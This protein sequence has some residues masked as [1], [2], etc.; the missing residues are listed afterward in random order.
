MSDGDFARL[1]ALAATGIGRFWSRNIT[2]GGA[3]YA[4][5]T[6]AV[7]R[8]DRSI[9][10]DLQYS[11]ARAFDRSHNSGFIDATIVYNFGYYFDLVSRM[12]PFVPEPLRRVLAQVN[13]DIE[14]LGTAAHEFGHSVL[15]ESEGKAT[16]Y[17]HKGTSSIFQSPLDTAPAHPATG[18]IDLMK[19]FSDDR[20]DDYFS[21]AIA[22]EEDVKRLIGLAAVD[23]DD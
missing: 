15:E 2:V 21:R 20:P 3:V 16:S 7:R 6:T 4:V 10:I 13:A 22:A 9:D 8:A 1:S 5:T 17:G 11:N 12:L 14:F 23:F 19:Y 18:E